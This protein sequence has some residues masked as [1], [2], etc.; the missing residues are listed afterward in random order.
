MRPFVL[1]TALLLGLVLAVNA[2]A[3][4]D[5]WHRDTRLR[6]AASTFRA[7]QVMRFE[8]QI[9]ERRF[10]EARVRAI[11]RPRVVA[12]GSSRVR[13]VS[14][15][16]ANA[17]PGAFYNLG[18]SAAIV[19]DYIALWS[20]LKRDDK[21]PETA[22]FSIDAWIFSRAQEQVS[23]LTL[24]REVSRFLDEVGAG[25][26]ALWLAAREAEYRW[27]QAREFLSYSTVRQSVRDLERALAGRKR[28]GD[29]LLGAL[30]GGLVLEGDNTGRQAIRADGSVI[31]SVP[32]VEPTVAQLRDDAVRYV[33]SGAY[34]LKGF[35]WDDTRAAHLELLWRDM[36][37][38][39]V[40][41]V[42]YAPPYH[43]TAWQEIAKHP[44]YVAALTASAAFLRDLA[45]RWLMPASCRS[46]P[47]VC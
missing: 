25:H 21:I 37:A 35:E 2:A 30:A 20:M 42:A 39:G 19:E 44:G 7:G 5:R 46:A 16:L 38:H 47:W 9:D 3:A 36:R 40:R 23:W 28:Q 15:R 18:M 24:A 45:A 11:P 32:A 29:D 22:I 27:L 31:R 17:A 41:I 14:S 6:D 4:L 10:Q 13:D 8:G 34:A 26:G 12:F 33:A 1:T 43:P